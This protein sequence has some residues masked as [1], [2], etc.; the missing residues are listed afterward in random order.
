MFKI[1]TRMESSVCLSKQSTDVGINYVTISFLSTPPNV[2]W[3]STG[4][5]RVNRPLGKQ[6]MHPFQEMYLHKNLKFIPL[7]I[8][9]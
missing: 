4:R 6:M 1:D 2:V 7:Y 5:M 3:D 9:E 8:S